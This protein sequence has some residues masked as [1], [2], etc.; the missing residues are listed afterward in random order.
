MTK[1]QDKLS[2]AADDYRDALHALA[3]ARATY[4]A[5]S[6]KAYAA[7][8]AR[9]EDLRTRIAT[10]ETEAETAQ[11]NFKRLFA[12][13]GHVVTK[14][15]R[16]A[17]NLKNDAL[18]IAEE[19]RIALQETERA[20]FEPSVTASKEA[21]HYENAHELAYV[22]YARR[23]VYQALAECEASMGRAMALM[24]HAPTPA[25]IEPHVDDVTEA[26][27]GFI[28]RE[29]KELAACRPEALAKPVVEE[30]GAVDL[31][32]F[33]DRKFLSP[34][35]AHQRRA[36]ARETAHAEAV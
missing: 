26:R 23:E 28:W 32:P 3:S 18:A 6:G 2:R 11:S 36:Q 22:A 8:L 17:L 20:A 1:I 9:Q 27:I 24:R 14:E 21:Q 16:N 34:A 15:V 30:L 4:E 5:G 29:L 13:T 19:L 35:E 31:G 33:S 10:N 25:G 12:G 7:L